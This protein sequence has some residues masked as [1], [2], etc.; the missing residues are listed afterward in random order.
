M[1]YKCFGTGDNKNISQTCTAKT[2]TMCGYDNGKTLYRDPQGYCSDGFIRSASIESESAGSGITLYKW[3]CIGSGIT[4]NSISA[5]EYCYA[6]KD[7]NGGA[8]VDQTPVCGE[9][10]NKAL[11]I[12]DY[13]AGFVVNKTTNG[14]YPTIYEKAVNECSKLCSVGYPVLPLNLP[15]NNGTLSY[16]CKNGSKT[17]TCSIYKNLSY[18]GRCGILNGT[19]VPNNYSLSTV[20]YYNYNYLCEE[21]IAPQSLTKTG[22]QYTWTCQGDTSKSMPS[23]NCA[24]NIV[25]TKVD[26]VCGSDNGRRLI[27]SSDLRNACLVGTGGSVTTSGNIIK[28]NCVG[29]NSGTTASCSAIKA[30]TFGPIC[31]KISLSNTITQDTALCEAGEA[32]IV[33]SNRWMCKGGSMI[34]CSRK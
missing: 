32:I 29:Y 34:N 15:T 3:S 11:N 4:V 1:T 10:N 21:G 8:S 27:D 17:T 12:Q 26:G 18:S 9:Y 28:W 23:E 22:S 7:S 31:S 16:T 19:N 5:T 25:S 20:G 30:G 33:D 14:G 13:G 2:S 6:Y 24:A